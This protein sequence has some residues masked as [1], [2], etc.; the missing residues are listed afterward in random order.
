MNF[1][2]EARY[3]TVK[4]SNKALMER[5]FTDPPGA[6]VD[7]FLAAG[8]KEE[9]DTLTY[10]N[11]PDGRCRAVW[12]MLQRAC[13]DSRIAKLREEDKSRPGERSFG[14]EGGRHQ[15]GGGRRRSAGGG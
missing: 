2:A 9:E 4:K 11:E 12:E 3:R 8:F 5:L 10:E 13:R 6:A 14:G 1:P 7:L 15:L